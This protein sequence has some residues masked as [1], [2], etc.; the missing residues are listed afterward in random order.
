MA[1]NTRPSAVRTAAAHVALSDRPA[2]STTV[3]FWIIV[4]VTVAAD[5][6]TKAL[7]VE[8]L[9]PRHMPHRIIGDVVRFTLSY[10][11]GAAFG[12][13]LG[14]GSRWIFAVLSIVIVVVLLRATSDLTR[15]SRLAALGVPV[16]VGGAIGNLLD[17]IRLRE[18]VV[19][20]IDIGIGTT[21]FWTF[22]VADTAVT[23]GAACLVIALWQEDQAL[24][25]AA[26]AQPQ[27]PDGPS[28]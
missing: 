25:A 23:I 13:H 28:A 27:P 1:S 26:K 18:G 22:N 5:F 15:T 2:A 4:A 19:D 21:R 16:I 24:L 7:A 11:P 8:H 17:R 12:M 10:N 6:V 14:P 20:F 3:L 9:V